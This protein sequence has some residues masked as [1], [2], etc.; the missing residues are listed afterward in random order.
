MRRRQKKMVESGERTNNVLWQRHK[1]EDPL[2]LTI[3]NEALRDELRQWTLEK[4]V[5]TGVREGMT[6]EFAV[7]VKN[8]NDQWEN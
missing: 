5:F 3:W 1:E 2:V 6:K 8:K 7:I 4:I